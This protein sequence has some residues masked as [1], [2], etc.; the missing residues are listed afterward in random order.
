M[1]GSVE[2]QGIISRALNMAQS[3]RNGFDL[4]RIE[5]MVKNAVNHIMHLLV[6]FI[7]Q[8][9]L[10]PLGFFYSVTRTVKWIWQLDWLVFLEGKTAPVRAE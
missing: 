10:I 2:Q 4:D 9:I 6:L 3:V 7:L 8:S 1:N 5:G